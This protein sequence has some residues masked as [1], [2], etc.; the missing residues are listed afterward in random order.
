MTEDRRHVLFE[1]RIEGPDGPDT[2]RI[3][4]IFQPDGGI[5]FDGVYAGPS[6]EKFWGDWDHEFWMDIP[7]SHAEAFLALV[8]RD[9]FTRDGRLTYAE[10][11]DLCG[12]AGIPIKEGH[13][14]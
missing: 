12:G 9:A 2:T 14:T 8:A 4:L 11:R 7:A 13:W 3:D 6:A 5:K 1:E 10:L